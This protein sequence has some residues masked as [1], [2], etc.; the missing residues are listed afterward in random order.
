M[1]FRYQSR[2]CRDDG[3]IFARKKFRAEFGSLESRGHG[4]GG[5]S[6]TP[7]VVGAHTMINSIMIS[8]KIFL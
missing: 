4:V 5:L 6:N 1:V 2:T 7:A 3:F 8:E